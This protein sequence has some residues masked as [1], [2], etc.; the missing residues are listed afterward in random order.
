MRI[1]NL[2]LMVALIG[3]LMVAATVFAL[4][5]SDPP[6]PAPT[7]DLDVLILRLAD[8]NVEVSRLAETELR[9]RGKEAAAH[10]E[11][12]SRSSDPAL[13]ARSKKLLEEL[14]ARGVE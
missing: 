13:S 12:A 1:G 11:R 14:T 10:L 5:D 8:G 4:R 6:P 2:I 9:K 3:G 7:A